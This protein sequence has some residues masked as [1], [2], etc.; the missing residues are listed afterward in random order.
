MRMLVDLLEQHARDQFLF[1]FSDYLPDSLSSFRLSSND[2]NTS[3]IQT[4][5]VA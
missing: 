4:A 5:S 1:F 2:K 3:A